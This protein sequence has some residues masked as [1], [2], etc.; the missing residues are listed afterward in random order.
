MPLKI[1][2]NQDLSKN[3]NLYQENIKYSFHINLT[4]N[5]SINYPNLNYNNTSNIRE[6]KHN[7]FLLPYN[8]PYYKN[9]GSG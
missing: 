1:N 5:R 7:I 4:K 3:N 8:F 6:F 2:S 9:C